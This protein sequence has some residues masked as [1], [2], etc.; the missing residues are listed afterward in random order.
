MALTGILEEAGTDPFPR[1]SD[2]VH[3]DSRA[4]YETTHLDPAQP[5]SG[6]GGSL[7]LYPKSRETPSTTTIDAGYR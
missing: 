7:A 3:R 5:D 4:L 6:V 2:G 1:G